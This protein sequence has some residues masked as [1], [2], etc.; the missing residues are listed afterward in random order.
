MKP[1]G[2]LLG[3]CALLLLGCASP[4]GL[5]YID[6]EN[7]QIGNSADW[8]ETFLN[9]TV[10]Y[11][12]PNKYAL[13][14]K[15]VNCE[16]YIDSAYIGDFKF[17]SL[18]I[19]PALDTINFPI[20]V[21]VPTAQILRIGITMLSNEVKFNITGNAKVGRKGIFINMPLKYE[22]TQKLKL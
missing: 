17:D 8:K 16:L 9:A 4:K 10:K 13:Q 18:M 19:L 11:F 12:N 2:L 1:L 7:I 5:Q 6:T 22:G 20:A 21:K 3:I 15:N 14:V